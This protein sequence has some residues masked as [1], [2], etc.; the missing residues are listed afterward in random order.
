VRM[1]LLLAFLAVCPLVL[2]EA[3]PSQAKDESALVQNEKTWALALEH[4]DAQAV[5]CLLADEFQDADPSGQ[6]HDRA[7][8]LAGVPKRK[9]GSNH[10]SEMHAHVYGDFG[11]IRGLAT[12]VDPQ[13]KTVAK[14]RFT[15]VYA[16]RDGRWVCLAGHESMLPEVK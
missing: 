2:A 16:Y 15:D 7:E 4:H 1:T 6:L 10:L 8:T 5:G 9:P 14:V 11:Y 3:C 12:L 13:G